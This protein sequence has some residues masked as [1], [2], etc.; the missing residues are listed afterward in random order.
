MKLTA[1]LVLVVG[2]VA[3]QAAGQWNANYEV[4]NSLLPY[5]HLNS[6]INSNEL[7]M[8][9]LLM[10]RLVRSDDYGPFV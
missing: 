7:L 5:E 9:R 6:I 3:H 8:K 2:V 4:T 1:I 10:K